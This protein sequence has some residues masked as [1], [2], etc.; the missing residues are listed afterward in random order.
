[1]HLSAISYLTSNAHVMGALLLLAP[2]LA[3]L[4]VHGRADRLPHDSPPQERLPLFLEHDSRTAASV[5]PNDGRVDG[6]PG[7]DSSS[8]GSGSP[9][10]GAAGRRAGRR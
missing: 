9:A 7:R 1:M 3:V 6:S 5:K 10:R 2:S 4:L 8:P